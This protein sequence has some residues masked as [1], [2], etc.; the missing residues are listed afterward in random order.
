MNFYKPEDFIIYQPTNDKAVN[1]LLGRLTEEIY[2]ATNNNKKEIHPKVIEKFIEK[3]DDL[4]LLD[5][6]GVQRINE[7]KTENKLLNELNFS[8]IMVS[9]SLDSVDFNDNKGNDNSSIHNDNILQNSH[10]CCCTQI[11]VK[12]YLI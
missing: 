6:V 3:D 12:Q 5:N 2:R 4:Y 10:N 7:F 9:V 11:Y 1:E 8:R